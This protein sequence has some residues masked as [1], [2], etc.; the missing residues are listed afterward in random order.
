MKHIVIF[1]GT[2]EGRLLTETLSKLNADITVCVATEYGK[3]E[4]GEL[5]GVTV[6]SGRLDV[7]GMEEILKG[8]ALCIDATHPYAR[9]AS[10]NIREACCRTGVPYKRLL[11]EQSELPQTAVAVQTMKEAADY[12]AGCS[13]NV[14][15]TTGSK[16][17]SAFSCIDRKRLFVRVLP[18]IESLKLCEA[19]EILPGNILAL[20]GPFSCEFNEALIHQFQI[21]YLVTKDGGSVG[22][23][24]EKVMAAEKTGIELIVITRPRERGESF[25]KVLR[26]CEEMLK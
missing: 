17:L 7:S 24:K 10:C 12:L 18:L 26:D 1:G 22:G 20:Q 25:E 11:R 9:E 3:T 8:T 5:S 6:H 19:A 21:K 4:Q 14:L 23:F 13:G 15:L 16:E 2:T